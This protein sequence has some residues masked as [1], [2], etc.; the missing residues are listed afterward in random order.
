[1]D[2]IRVNSL[3]PT[4]VY[5]NQDPSFVEQLANCIPLGR[6]ANINEL[7]GPIVFLA[8]EASS[9]ITGANLIVD[10]GRTIW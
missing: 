10:G 4:G 5:R 2:G 7:K 6:M 8:S 9:F 3:S 1:M